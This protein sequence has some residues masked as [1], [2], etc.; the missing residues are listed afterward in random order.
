MTMPVERTRALRFGWE[1]LLDLR[2]SNCISDR[3]RTTVNLILRHYPCASEIQTWARE[4][5]QISGES[6]FGAADLAPEELPSTRDA[7]GAKFSD[8]FERAPTSPQERTRAL[9]L[10]ADFFRSGLRGADK[11]ALT[12]DLRRQIPYV[13]RYFPTTADVVRWAKGYEHCMRKAACGQVW[14]LP[15]GSGDGDHS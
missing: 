5:A 14:L 9:C 2:D 10:A 8:G 12:D 13:L 6:V 15:A 3:Q 1:F 11:D 4:C 7:Y